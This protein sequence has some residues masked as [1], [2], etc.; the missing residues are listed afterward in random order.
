MLLPRASHQCGW[1]CYIHLRHSFITNIE[2]RA[3]LGFP[4]EKKKDRKRTEKTSKLE[5]GN[6]TFK[7]FKNCCS[8][9]HRSKQG[10]QVTAANV[11]MWISKTKH[12]RTPQ[13]KTRVRGFSTGVMEVWTP[14]P[15]LEERLEKEGRRQQE[16]LRIYIKIR[17]A[18]VKLRLTMLPWIRLAVLYYRCK[19]KAHDHVK[20]KLRKLRLCTDL[21]YNFFNRVKETKNIYIHSIRDHK[22]TVTG[23]RDR[24]VQGDGALS[25]SVVLEDLF[26]TF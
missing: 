25:Q 16:R 4:R 6:C 24:E 20:E 3:S 26:F 17:I 10:Q 11:Y 18:G 1:W 9:D 14:G 5:K 15:I 13:Q 7:Y 2:E 12:G 22:E 21:C 19:I 23:Q 8:D